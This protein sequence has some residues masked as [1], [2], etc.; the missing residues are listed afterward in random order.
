MIGVV[1]VRQWQPHSGERRNGG[2]MEREGRCLN[3]RYD[4]HVRLICKWRLSHVE[5]KGV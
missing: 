2:S 5:R 1:Y 3:S 4:H